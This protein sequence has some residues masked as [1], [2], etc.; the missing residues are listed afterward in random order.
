LVSSH[1]TLQRHREI[2]QLFI[3]GILG[4]NFPRPLSFY[5][6]RY[7]QY[8]EEVKRLIF[9]EQLTHSGEVAKLGLGVVPSSPAVIK[10]YCEGRVRPMA[11]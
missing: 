8:L 4:S 9:D 5:L 7:E 10:D 6:S 3:D 2:S 11:R 1:F